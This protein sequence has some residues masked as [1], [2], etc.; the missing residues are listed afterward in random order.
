MSSIHY[1]LTLHFMASEPVAVARKLEL[2]DPASGAYL[3]KEAPILSAVNVL[4]SMIPSV[5]AKLFAYFSADQY[6]GLSQS[7]DVADLAAILRHVDPDTRQGII[8]LLAKRKQAL[9][10]ILINYPE[11]SVGSMVETDVFI[12]DSHM[13][14]ADALKRLKTRHYTYLQWVYVVNHNRQLLGSIFIGDLL[15]ADPLSD[16]G[17]LVQV[18]V[19]KIGANTDLLAAMDLSV[20]NHTDSLAVV[21]KKQEFIGVLHYFRLRHFISIKL[22][23]ETS[24]NDESVSADLLEIYS[25]TIVNMVD[26]IQPL[27]KTS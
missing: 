22:A 17:S 16:V 8:A 9:C 18:K 15:Q 2:V 3:I 1:N 5:A 19:A 7:M 21:N 6:V 25:D 27:D 23:H 26:L 24:T 20:W 12:L 14:V 10:K 11:H 4:K 13:P